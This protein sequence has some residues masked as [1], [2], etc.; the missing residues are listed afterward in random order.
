MLSSNRPRP[1]WL[2]IACVIAV[3][4]VPGFAIEVAETLLV[5]L[6]AANASAGT[7]VWENTGTLADFNEVGDPV[8]TTIAG[9]AAV[10]FDGTNAYVCAEPAP[11]EPEPTQPRGGPAQ[12]RHPLDHPGHCASTTPAVSAQETQTVSSHL[13]A[14]SSK[15]ARFALVACTIL[16]LSSLSR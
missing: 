4:A 2:L 12:R 7:P 6:S 16:P 10:A 1:A 8:L 9:I 3:P 15:R 14:S 11:A 13:I 5:N